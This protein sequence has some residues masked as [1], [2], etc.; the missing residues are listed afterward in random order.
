MADLE[1]TLDYLD[2]N[3]N[4]QITTNF[5]DNIEHLTR[6]I[7]DNPK[8]FPLINKKRKVRKCVVTKHNTI[9]YRENKDFIDILRV[10]D[11]RQNPS[12]AKS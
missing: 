10:F 3:W 6:L 8:L 7:S 12:A 1:N 11:T 9:Y 4:R 5:I 2:N